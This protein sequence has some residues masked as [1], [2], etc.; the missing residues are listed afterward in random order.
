MPGQG[1]GKTPLT[2]AE[3]CRIF[4]IVQFRPADTLL[5]PEPGGDKGT[6][7]PRNEVQG[8]VRVCVSSLIFLVCC[9]CSTFFFDHALP[10]LAGLWVLRPSI[11]GI[12][13]FL[14]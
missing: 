14:V 9:V 7:F 6:L 5:S 11:F 12:C 2:Q 10:L 4:V 8:Y 13:R 1:S 3:G